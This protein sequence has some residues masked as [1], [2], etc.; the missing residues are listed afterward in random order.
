M[1]N[2]AD[3]P[4]VD[5]FVHGGGDAALEGIGILMRQ[6]SAQGVSRRRRNNPCP[7][8]ATI[9]ID[10]RAEVEENSTPAATLRSSHA[11][12]V[13]RRSERCRSWSNGPDSKS[14]VPLRAPRVR[15]LASP[16]LK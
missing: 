2:I 9:P 15:I 16:P 10:S 3:A 6:A 4:G 12:S 1:V 11:P 7:F 8:A 14:G 5:A 13:P